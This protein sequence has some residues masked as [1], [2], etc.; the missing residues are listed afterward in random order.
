MFLSEMQSKEIVS[1]I[2][3]R[4]LG[5]IIDVNVDINNG[6]INYFV[7]EQRRFFKRFLNSNGEIKF[8]FDDIEKIGEDVILVKL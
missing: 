6:K 2:D 7:C 5:R 3:G 4:K 1:I 8:T